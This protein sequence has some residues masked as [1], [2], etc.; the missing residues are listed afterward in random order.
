M[1]A[2][3]RMYRQTETF[4][5]ISITNSGMTPILWLR[6]ELHRIKVLQPLKIK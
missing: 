6:R 4:V 1:A 3:F 2:V 5:S